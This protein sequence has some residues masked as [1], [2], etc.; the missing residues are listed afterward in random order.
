MLDFILGHYAYWFTLALMV[1]GLYGMMMKKNLVKKLIGMT[2][3]QVSIIIFYISSA[4]KWGGTVPIIDQ[5]DMGKIHH[6]MASAIEAAKYINPLPHTLMLT[7][8][9]VG[10]AT[11]GVAFALVII[12]YKRYKTLNEN[13][14]LKRMKKED[15]NDSDQ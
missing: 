13:E 8:I 11:T 3:F 14:L 1:I 10:V 6:G 2:I 15:D 5:S 4:V 7:A 12:I 9:V